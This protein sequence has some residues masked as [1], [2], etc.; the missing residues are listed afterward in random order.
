[1]EPEGLLP[2]FIALTPILRQMNSVHISTPYLFQIS[3]NIIISLDL[4]Y[5]ILH[6]DAQ[7]V[8]F[9]H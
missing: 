6:A 4:Q 2:W 1:M 3:F 7:V 8:H 5:R 9:K